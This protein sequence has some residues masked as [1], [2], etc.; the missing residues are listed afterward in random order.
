MT[1]ALDRGLGRVETQ[2]RRLLGWVLRRSVW[3]PLVLLLCLALTYGFAHYSA[4]TY[5]RILSPSWG[6]W[7]DV[8]EWVE[9]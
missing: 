8:L 7:G 6:R 3:M 4:A 9:E 5:S 2:Y 1:A